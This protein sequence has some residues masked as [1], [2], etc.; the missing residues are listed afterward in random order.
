MKQ[1]DVL[2]QK[3]LSRELGVRFADDFIAI[4]QLHVSKDLSFAKVWISSLRDID[5]VV[6]KCQ[7]EAASLRKLLSQTIVA[8]RVPSLYFVADKTE[9]KAAKIEQLLA[10]IKEKS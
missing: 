10:E 5:D 7:S 1:F 4:T 3:E 2:I 9:E 8:R 6:N